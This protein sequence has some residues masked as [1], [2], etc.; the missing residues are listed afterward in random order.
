MD[1]DAFFAS[2]E[3]AS[4]PNLRGKPVAVI[5][6][7]ERTV[8]VTSSYE[9]RKLGVKTGMSKYEALKVC[10]FLNV[11]VGRGRKY[12][13]ISKEIVAFLQKITPNVEPYSIDEA[14]MDIS[15]TG[16]EADDVAYMIKSY[17]KQNF[18]ITCSIGAGPNK[19]IAKMAS[20]IKKPDGYCKVDEKDVLNF[21]DGFRLKDFWGIGRRLAK[22]FESM[23]VFT[24]ADLRALGEGRLRQMFGITG[25]YLYK[26]APG[27]YFSIVTP[28]EPPVKSIGHS[29]TLPVNIFSREKA[30]N[31]ILQ[32]SDMV[33]VRARKNRYS[34]KVIAVTIRYPNMGT[35]SRMRTIPFF[36]AATHHIYEEAM[37]IFD[38]LWTGED[39]RL[40]GI[41][42]AGLIPE[43]VSLY[44]VADGTKKWDDLY[45]AMDKVN[46]KYGA[47]T[48]SFGS[49]LNCSRRG[50]RV[51]SPAWRPSGSRHIDIC[52]G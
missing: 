3:Q 39:I 36:T 46:G 6:A 20:G 42:I 22:R 13:Y 7:K 43:C 35:V 47:D 24:P 38:E 49:V 18:G 33:S 21:V 14:F 2:V 29:L 4:N 34:G 40:L 10:P 26:L 27:E 28:E 50:T 17:V 44:N 5:G 25:T 23:G 41:S 52:D 12:S 9:A 48:L 16:I 15:G 32:L 11:V 30:A 31:Y 37:I 8:V 51:I 45:G 1:M 19:F